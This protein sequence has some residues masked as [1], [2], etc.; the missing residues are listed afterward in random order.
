MLE[1]QREIDLRV[2]DAVASLSDAEAERDHYL[3]EIMIGELE[4]LLRTAN[5]HGLTAARAASA[6]AQRGRVVGAGEK[7]GVAG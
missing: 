7:L 5:L 2:D 6:L 4:S 1:F 3:A